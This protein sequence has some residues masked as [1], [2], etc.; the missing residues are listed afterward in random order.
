MNIHLVGRFGFGTVR[1]NLLPVSSLTDEVQ[2][3]VIG[4]FFSLGLSRVVNDSSS[5]RC[6]RPD[7]RIRIGGTSPSVSCLRSWL[8]HQRLWSCASG[9]SE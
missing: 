3:M 9:E 6:F 1:I 8:C 7:G 5:Y 4:R 2:V